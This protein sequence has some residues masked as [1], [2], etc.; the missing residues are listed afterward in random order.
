MSRAKLQTERKMILVRCD[1][2]LAARI[3]VY[4]ETEG[5]SVNEAIVIAVDRMLK[6][7]GL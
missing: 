5:I 6:E 7:R 3:K 2:E 4:A 1:L